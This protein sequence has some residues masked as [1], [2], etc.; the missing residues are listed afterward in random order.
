MRSKDGRY[1]LWHRFNVP[2]TENPSE[3]YLRRIYFIECPLFSILLHRLGGPDRSLDM[4]DHPWSFVSIILR[5]SYL[6]MYETWSNRVDARFVNWVNFKRLTTPHRI[7][8]LEYPDRPCWTLLFCG[9]RSRDWGFHTK[10][11]WVLYTKYDEVKAAR[12][13]SEDQASR[14]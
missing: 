9:P 13:F 8:A 2:D 10:R 4:H 7:V 14:V 12:A 5:N 11:G 6:E 1:K 3:D